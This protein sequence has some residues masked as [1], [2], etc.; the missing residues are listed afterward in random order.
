M[1]RLGYLGVT[2]GMWIIR[3]FTGESGGGK[4]SVDQIFGI[5]KVELKRRVAC[6]RGDLDISDAITLARALNYKPIKKTVNYAVTFSREGVK[7]PVLNKSAKEARLQSHSTR[8]YMYDEEGLPTYA[9]IE[10]Q[11][12]LPVEG[13]EK[14]VELRGMWPASVTPFLDIIPASVM[15]GNTVAPQILEPIASATSV[16]VSKVDKD[17]G[18]HERKLLTEAQTLAAK[19]YSQ[20]RREMWMRKAESDAVRCGLS[21]YIL[22]SSAGKKFNAFLKMKKCHQY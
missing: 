10:E 8:S 13:A 17:S 21:A 22:C 6:G 4:S 16:Y 14:L 19:E 3:H 15:L 12:Y 5:C 18:L 1:S 11:S 9:H 2:V 7:D 20:S